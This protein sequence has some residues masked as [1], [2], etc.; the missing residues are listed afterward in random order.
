MKSAQHQA[1]E[2]FRVLVQSLLILLPVALL[3]AAGVASKSVSQSC[4]LSAEGGS[5]FGVP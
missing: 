4:P 5:L 3:I 1:A 2:S